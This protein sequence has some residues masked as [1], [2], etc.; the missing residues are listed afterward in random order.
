[1]NTTKEIYLKTHL[2]EWKSVLV[3]HHT[4]FRTEIEPSIQG[5]FASK[6]GM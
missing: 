2:S 4:L 5:F 3:V 1:M 6:L